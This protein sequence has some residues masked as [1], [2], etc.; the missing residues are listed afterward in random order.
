MRVGLIIS[1]I[2]H[3]AI[4]LWIMVAPGEAPFDPARADAV[5]VDLVS[6]KE[7]PPLAEPEPAK[8]ETAKPELPA[9]EPPK[10]E[11]APATSK[12][13]TLEPAA[14]KSAPRKPEPA[15]A[16]PTKAEP[17]KAEPAKAEPAKAEPAKAEPAKAEP[18][19]AEPAKPVL[20]ADQKPPQ[21]SAAETP[22]SAQDQAAPA[23]SFAWMLN[24]PADALTGAGGLPS[25]SGSK[26]SSEEIAKFKA[27]VSQCWVAPAN[28]P[29]NTPGFNVLVRIVLK[30]DGALGADPGLVLAPASQ[31]GPLLVESATRALKQCQP[32]DFLPAD[33]YQ[34]WKILE[35]SFS[36]YGPSDD[37][38]PPTL[39]NAF[40]H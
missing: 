34:D 20:E 24:L 25:E 39:N 1:V 19:K 17:A 12:P 28:V 7:V 3:V 29:D 32:Y 13:A 21:K 30:P 33:K 37:L 8:P 36:V 31:S 10:T 40:P 16:E 27:R 23:A 26:L 15:K 14:R 18:A 5:L 9:F 35:L 38:G 22:P 6:P 11:L 4:F 2:V